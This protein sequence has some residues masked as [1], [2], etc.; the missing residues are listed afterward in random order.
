MEFFDYATSNEDVFTIS[1]SF[2]AGEHSINLS[3]GLCLEIHKHFDGVFITSAKNKHS[4]Y[5]VHH[6]FH[7]TFRI[8][9]SILTVENERD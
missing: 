5:E 7:L 9:K 8:P 1:G 4:N 2:F 6:T 3:I